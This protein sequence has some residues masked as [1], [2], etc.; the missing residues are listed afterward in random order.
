MFIFNIYPYAFSK[1]LH[2]SI[3]VFTTANKTTA[4]IIFIFFANKMQIPVIILIFFHLWGKFNIGHLIEQPR[5]LTC[6]DGLTGY[7]I[8]GVYY[9]G[10]IHMD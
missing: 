7:K 10:P 6:N 5:M 3:P 9:L 1:E 8:W 2:I 4:I